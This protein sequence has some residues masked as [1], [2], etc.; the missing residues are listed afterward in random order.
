MKILKFK[1]SWCNP[2]KT[3]T[4][5]MENVELPFEVTELDIEEDMQE[6]IKFSVR[7]VPT[8]LLVDDNDTVVKSFVGL[9]KNQQELMDIFKAA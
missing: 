6:A 1:A 7:G 4:K 5:M 9:P 3:L 2:C 8:M